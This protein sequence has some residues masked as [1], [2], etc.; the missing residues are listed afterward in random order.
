MKVS[1]EKSDLANVSCDVLIVGIHKGSTMPRQL[2]DLDAKLG[3]PIS[4]LQKDGHFTADWGK[5]YHLSTFGKSSV[6]SLLLIG[7]GESKDFSLERLR[8]ASGLASKI[9][10]DF[11]KR[12]VTALGL[13]DIR[14]TLL[15]QRIQAIAEGAMLSAYRFDKYRSKDKQDDEPSL[16]I[17]SERHDDDIKQVMREGSIVSGMVNL[18]RDL[19]HSPPSVMTPEQ[20]AKVARKIAADY[21]CSSRVFGRD[22]IYSKNLHG[23]YAVSKGSTQEPRFII[24]EH[25]HKDARKTLCFIGKGITFDSG[26]ISIKPA[27]GMDEMKTDMAGAAAVMGAIGA[28]SQLDLKINVIGIMPCS[29]NM[30]GASA[31]KPGDIIKTHSKK[32]VEVLNTDAEGRIV[33]A[34][35]LSYAEKNYKPDAIIDVATLTGACMVALGREAAGLISNDDKLADRIIHASQVSS[36]RVWRLPLYDEYRD[37]VKSKIADVKNTGL[38]KGEAGAITAGAFLESFVEK[39]PWAHLDIAG[40]ACHKDEKDYIPKGGSG[41]GVRL[42]V[43]LAKGWA[44]E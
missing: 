33:L 31:Y 3:S 16:L 34:D 5:F 18:A 11:G 44:S 35:A 43:H 4:H 6:K 10:P 12:I 27:D 32:T 13:L 40:P 17:L 38:P 23:L 24:L 8:R 19:V 20:M 22:E 28:I 2:Q 37:A 15:P 25:R 1:I 21:G 29:E 9:A 42:L 39:A 14:S 36:E 7:L 26:G 30:P 41:F